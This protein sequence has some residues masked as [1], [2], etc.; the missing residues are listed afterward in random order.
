MSWYGE[1]QRHREAAFKL[2]A[3]K[4]NSA[5]TI[6]PQNKTENEV[7][8]LYNLYVKN[9]PDRTD[10]IP[11]NFILF[12]KHTKSEIYPCFNHRCY[13]NAFEMVKSNS[14]IYKLVLGLTFQRN[15]IKEL[16]ESQNPNLVHEQY[17][18]PY[19]HAWLIN[20]NQE[21]V[22][23]T[24]GHEAKNYIYFGFVVNQVK[25]KELKNEEDVGNY[26]LDVIYERKKS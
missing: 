22:D 8:R 26:L 21:I 10:K 18:I 19:P 17:I 16:V 4:I 6:K 25:L 5:A 7:K 1:S 24:F 12:D 9:N 13:K 3:K 14:N 11:E 23:Y 15:Q 2:S 20:K